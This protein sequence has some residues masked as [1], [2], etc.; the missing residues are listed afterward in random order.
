MNELES[1]GLPPTIVITEQAEADFKDHFAYLTPGNP[2]RALAFFG[3]ARDAFVQLAAMPKLGVRR[4]F[5]LPRLQELRMWPVPGF[6]QY[7][8]FYRPLSDGLEIIRVLHH[9]RDIAAAL[10][11]DV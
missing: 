7:L 5:F 3:A 1:L 6:R 4:S 2:D 9:S 11:D 8:I 10:E